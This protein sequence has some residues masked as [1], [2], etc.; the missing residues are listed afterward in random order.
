MDG[1]AR[2]WV[3][4]A[5]GLLCV[6]VLVKIAW[7]ADDALIT[8]R[9]ALNFVHGYGA[10]FNIDERVQAY[11]HPAWFLLVSGLLALVHNPFLV[12]WTLS[13][14]CALGACVLVAERLG[15][16]FWHGAAG[17]VLLLMSKA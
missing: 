1:P 13:F 12:L 17:V 2:V 14:V 6:V 5:L 7:V 16:T 3:R 10:T 8:V 9:S 15:R 11:T 4:V